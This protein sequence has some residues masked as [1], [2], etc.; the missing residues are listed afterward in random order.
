MIID[1]KKIAGEAI[2]KLK[3]RPA[4]KKILA[5]ILVGNAAASEI[6]LKQKEK[7]AAELGVDFRIYRLSETLSGDALRKKIGEI[8]R[9]GSVGGV[10]VQLP[11]PEKFNRQAILNAIPREKDVDVLSERSLGAFYAGRGLVLPPAAGALEKILASVNFN[12]KGAKIAVVGLG[13][14][15]GKPIAVWLMG[16]AG[17]ICLIDEGGDLSR[18]AAADLVVSGVGKAGLLKPA[19]LKE[20]AVVVDFGCSFGEGGKA[21]GD[22]AADEIGLR[23]DISYTPV[24]GGAGPV[25]VAQLFDNFFR[26]FTPRA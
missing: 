3:S 16:K 25:L 10:I 14:L 24:P 15:V 8:A 26:L 18:V 12:L 2:E 4:P 23:K 6:F 1:G 9:Q 13:S 20:N 17:N 7:T 21:L 5:A 19:M 11:L 22:F